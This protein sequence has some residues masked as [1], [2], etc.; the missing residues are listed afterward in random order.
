MAEVNSLDMHPFAGKLEFQ[1]VTSLLIDFLPLILFVVFPLVI[2]VIAFWVYAIVRIY[3]IHLM[4]KNIPGHKT[5]LIASIVITVLPI[6][7]SFPLA[8]IVCIYKILR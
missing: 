1:L 8:T 2:V 7:N 3:W 6:L 4:M 5:I